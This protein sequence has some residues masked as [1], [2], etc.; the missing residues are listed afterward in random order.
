MKVE[1][2]MQL[3]REFGFKVAFASF[4]SSAFTHPMAITRWRD[5][6]LINYLR[7][8]CSDVLQKYKNLP[9]NNTNEPSNIIW[10]IWWQ[11]EEN[12]PEVVKRC[13]ASVRKHCI[14]KDFK[15]ITK[16]NFRDYI[17]LPEYIIKKVDQGMITLTHLSD[18]LRM[19][20]L[21]NYGGLWL[22]ATIFVTEKIP[23]EIFLM[24]YFTIKREAIPNDFNVGQRRWTTFLQAA[25]KRLNFCGF[26]YEIMLEYWKKHET[27][28]NYVLFDYII[29]LAYEELPE[30]RSMLDELPVN[31]PDVDSIQA[32]LNMQFDEKK[33][34]DLT[35]N[36]NF[37]KLTWKDQFQKNIAGSETF[38]G[39][40]MDENFL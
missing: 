26:V 35:Q 17:Q 32:L 27:V 13:F 19:Y 23:D 20:L 12:A 38:Y 9:E 6:V 3:Y 31:N 22:D 39:K 29:A 30:F 5:K 18:I 10:S 40:I 11:G 14:G 2:V 37:F 33:F 25:H 36:T 1:K 28:F 16:N 24:P 4:C 34:A 15:I 7:K 21:Y 8:N